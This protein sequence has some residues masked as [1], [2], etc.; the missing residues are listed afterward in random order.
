MYVRRLTEIELGQ[1]GE[2][3]H[4]DFPALLRFEYLSI[5]KGVTNYNVRLKRAYFVGCVD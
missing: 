3:E 5:R 1:H 4:P 2:H